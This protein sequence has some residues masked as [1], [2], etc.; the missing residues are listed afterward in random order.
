MLNSSL[1]CLFSAIDHHIALVLSWVEET[2]GGIFG[3]PG[4]LGSGPLQAL[5]SP[6]DATWHLWGFGGLG[7]RGIV[8]ISFLTPFIEN[9]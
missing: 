6:H 9:K 7:L 2:L 8:Y 4:G 1:L 5:I 3:W